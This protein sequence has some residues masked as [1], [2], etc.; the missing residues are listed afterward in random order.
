MIKRDFE[1]CTL[2]CCDCLE[3]LPTLAP[4]SV[5]LVLTDPPYMVQNVSNAVGVL[6]PWADISNGARFYADLFRAFNRVL[7]QSG[8]ALAFTNWHGFPSY[9]KGAFDANFPIKDLVVWNKETMACGQFF[10]RSYELIA[11]LPK[12]DFVMAKRDVRDVINCKFT[13]RETDHPAEKPVSLEVRLLEAIPSA[14]IVLDPFM[15]SGTTGVACV[16]TGRRFIGIEMNE[17][18]FDVAC[19]RI[20]AASRQLKLDFGGV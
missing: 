13:T 12:S 7:K 8:A 1:H 5:D 18:Y 4:Q 20:E 3:I 14:Q 6:N 15:G 2:Y 10:R 9:Y 17:H 16:Q 11:L 19:R